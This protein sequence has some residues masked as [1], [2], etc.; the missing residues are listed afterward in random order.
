MVDIVSYRVTIGLFYNKI[1]KICLRKARKVS[2]CLSDFIDMLL[3]LALIMHSVPNALKLL[4]ASKPKVYN[5]IFIE[6]FA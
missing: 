6:T 3:S 4:R 5:F 1:S 2:V